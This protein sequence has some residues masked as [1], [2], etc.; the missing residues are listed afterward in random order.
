VGAI[1]STTHVTRLSQTAALKLLGA[2]GCLSSALSRNPELCSAGE[3]GLIAMLESSKLLFA[4]LLAA[5][6]ASPAPNGNVRAVG[7][8][9]VGIKAVVSFC[10]FPVEKK[11]QGN[12]N[13]MVIININK[14]QRMES[15][16]S[17]K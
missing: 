7:N 12:Y 10:M 2:T 11:T 4:A 8:V 15:P 9:D 17:C 3:A 5:E 16:V 13:V 14:M 1:L 6:A